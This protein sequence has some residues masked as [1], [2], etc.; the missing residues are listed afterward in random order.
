MQFLP[1]GSPLGKALPTL[2]RCISQPSELVKAEM[3]EDPRQGT[4]TRVLRFPG[5][6]L[7]FAGI[8]EAL[9]I[10]IKAFTLHSL[11]LS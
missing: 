8:N 6:C 4:C 2:A 10:S 1:G 11:K 5:P 3:A 9:V 7:P